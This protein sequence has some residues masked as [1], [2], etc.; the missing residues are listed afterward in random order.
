M[1]RLVGH[2]DMHGIAIGVRIDGDRGNAHLARRLDDAAG[3]LAT[4]GDQD[5]GE[6]ADIPRVGR[7]FYDLYRRGQAGWTNRGVSI[8]LGLKFSGSWPKPGTS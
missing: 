7:S 1:H 8:G 3:D 5:L 2:L 4:V 6:H